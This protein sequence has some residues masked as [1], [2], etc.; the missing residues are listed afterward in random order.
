MRQQDPQRPMCSLN[1]QSLEEIERS[2]YSVGQAQRE[3]A[4]VSCQG[5]KISVAISLNEQGLSVQAP[6]RAGLCFYFHM[7][8]SV[9]TIYCLFQRKKAGRKKNLCIKNPFS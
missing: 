5:L 1:S 2:V 8:Y 3:P 9:H 7:L 6:E 4:K